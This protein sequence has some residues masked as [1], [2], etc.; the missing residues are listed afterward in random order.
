MIK[1]FLLKQEN[2]FRPSKDSKR[3]RLYSLEIYQNYRRLLAQA[4]YMAVSTGADL[5]LLASGASSDENSVSK[6]LVRLLYRCKSSRMRR[7]VTRFE[8][9]LV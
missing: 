5:A 9:N 3:C 7:F 2:L 6:V 1:D 4:L 8:S